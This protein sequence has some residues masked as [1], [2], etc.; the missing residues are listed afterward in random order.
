MRRAAL[1]GLVMAAF[2]PGTALACMLPIAGP[3]ERMAGRYVTVAV[4]TVVEVETRAPDRPNRAFNAVFE[5]D[6]VVEGHPQSGRLRLW[7]EEQTECPRVL[8]LPVVG[9][10]WVAYLEWDARGNGP[11][12]D[13]W[14]LTW[15]ERLDARFGGDPEAGMRDLE[16]P[17]GD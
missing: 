16:P 14:P 13:A 2:I 9:E 11:V 4:A 7:H 17:D 1:I 12:G 5:I 10:T 15:S 8:P 6:R 3:G